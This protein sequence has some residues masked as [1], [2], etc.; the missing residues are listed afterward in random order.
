MV[1]RQYHSGGLV[2]REMDKLQE[3]IDAIEQYIF[4]TTSGIKPPEISYLEDAKFLLCEYIEGLKHAT[5]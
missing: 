4:E 1:H 3:V 2:R 5:N